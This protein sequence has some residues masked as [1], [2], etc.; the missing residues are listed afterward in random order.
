[1]EYGLQIKT[2]SDNK[3]Q[4]LN[5]RFQYKAVIHYINSMV[6]IVIYFNVSFPAKADIRDIG[7]FY[8]KLRNIEYSYSYIGTINLMS[9][10]HE[11]TRFT[12]YNIQSR[13]VNAMLIM[14]TKEENYGDRRK[15]N[16]YVSIRSR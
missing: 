6:R 3:E 9:H 14:K 1:M 12:L 2:R 8:L 7:V 15:T 16:C 10:S 11:R 13:N 5:V 4:N